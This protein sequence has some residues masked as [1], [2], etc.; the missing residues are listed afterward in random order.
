[1]NFNHLE[2][3]GFSYIE[4]FIR[5]SRF[6]GILLFASMKC[7]VHAVLPFLLTEIVQDTVKSLKQ[8]LY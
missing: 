1:M 2:E 5:A 8:A 4:H 3:T 6:A 7:F